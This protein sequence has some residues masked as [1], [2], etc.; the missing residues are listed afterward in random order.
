MKAHTDM[1]GFM[2]SGSLGFKK[3]KLIVALDEAAYLSSL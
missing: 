1:E 3:K 2:V